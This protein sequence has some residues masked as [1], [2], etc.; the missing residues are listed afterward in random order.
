VG[1]RICCL[2][3]VLIGVSSTAAAD[4]VTLKTG[5]SLVGSFVNVTGTT[6]RFRSDAL[7]TI[8]IPLR[9]IAAITPLPAS[10]FARG[11]PPLTGDLTLESSG[12]WQIVAAADDVVHVIRAGDVN[13]ILPTAAYL[14]IVNHEAT[15]WQDWTGTASFGYSVQRASQE[16][17]TFSTILNTKRERPAS[18]VFEP[19]WRTTVHLTALLSNAAEAETSIGS[20]TVN[21]SL[22]Q[23]AFFAPDN[24]VFGV[25]QYD[26]VGAQGLTLRQT[27]GGGAGYDFTQ[28]ARTSLSVIAGLTFVRES[29]ITNGNQQTAQALFGE[30]LGLQLTDRVRLDHMLNV[31]PNITLPGEYHFDTNTS[32]TIKLTD[33][34]SLTTGVIDLF[35]SNPA[36]GSERNNFALTTGLTATF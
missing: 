13:V 29:F 27:Y 6:L 3:I 23:D 1:R 11:Q 25:V 14:A 30:K 8:S 10:V 12:D 33:R 15:P 2:L 5:E 36:P 32:V 35:L 18:P 17:N 26:H 9:Q 21:A 22:R 4:V 7:G 16:T 19:H 20:N 34:F 28:T 31:Y 24:F